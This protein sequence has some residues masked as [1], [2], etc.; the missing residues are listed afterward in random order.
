VAFGSILLITVALG[1]FGL[2]FV[3]AF[4]AA[5][6]AVM[7]VGPGLGPEVGPAS[8]FAG[9]PDGAKGLIAFAMVLG[10]LEFFTLLILRVPAFW[11][12]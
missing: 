1:A 7:N 10:R 6:T 11:R 4:S 3:T 9:L 8:T 5:V 2:D 12:D